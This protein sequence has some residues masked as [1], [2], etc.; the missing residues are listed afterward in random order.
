MAVECCVR[1]GDGME[2]LLKLMEKVWASDGIEEEEVLFGKAGFLQVLLFLRRISPKNDKIVSLAKAVIQ[3]Y[4]DREDS[5][6]TGDLQDVYNYFQ[7]HKKCYF[8]AAHGIAGVIHSIACFGKDVVG[9]EKWSVLMKL[10]KKLMTKHMFESGNMPSSMTSEKDKLVHWCHGSPGFL[11]L[12]SMLGLDSFT[13]KLSENVWKNGLLHTKGPGLCHGIS[14]NG[15]CML[16]HYGRTSDDIQLKRALFYAHVLS[17]TWKDVMPLADS[18]F[19]LY[20]GT[21]GAI[22]YVMD[23]IRALQ[24]SKDVHFPCYEYQY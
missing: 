1:D 8:G 24:G 6:L 18:P 15:Y 23:C 17:Q 4:F 2:E 10:F 13:Q 9:D 3:R 20:T 16:S 11:L 12:S 21:C 14:G 5:F 19:S 22:L 7:W